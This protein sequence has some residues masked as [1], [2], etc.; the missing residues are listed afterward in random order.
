MASM[1]RQTCKVLVGDAVHLAVADKN[2]LRAA[3]DACERT[4]TR[5]NFLAVLRHGLV[6]ENAFKVKEEM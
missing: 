1:G 4:L 2:V 5:V 6:G 3:F